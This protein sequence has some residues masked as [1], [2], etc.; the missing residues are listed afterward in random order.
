MRQLIAA[1][2]LMSSVGAPAALA[3]REIPKAEGH[4][5]CPLGYVNTLGS[6]CVSPIYYEVAPTYGKACLSG[7]MNIGAGYCRKKKGPLGIF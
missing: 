1:L 2:V 6:T 7:W 3:Q 4:D 5:Q